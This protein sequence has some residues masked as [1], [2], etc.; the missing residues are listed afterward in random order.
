MTAF[1]D[2]GFQIDQTKR[3][4]DEDD[5]AIRNQT[6]II[7]FWGVIKYRDTFGKHHTFRFRLRSIALVVGT[8][9]VWS[10]GAHALGFED[11]D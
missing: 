1:K 8:P 4:T 6:K 7:F 2:V 11:E 3:I 10:M 9:N 5:L